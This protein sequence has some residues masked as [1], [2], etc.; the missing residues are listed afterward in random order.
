MLRLHNSALTHSHISSSARHTSS[1]HPT[2][3]RSQSI[4][5]ILVDRFARPHSRIV[6]THIHTFHSVVSAS[7]FSRLAPSISLH[8]YRAHRTA[9][10]CLDAPRCPPARRW[11]PSA[12]HPI[13]PCASSDSVSL[14]PTRP[15]QSIPPSSSPSSPPTVSI[16]SHAKQSYRF[17]LL[18]QLRNVRVHRLSAIARSIR[19][20]RTSNRSALIRYT[21]EHP[22][23]TSLHTLLTREC[24]SR[25]ECSSQSVGSRDSRSATS[26]DS[27]DRPRRTTNSTPVP[28]DRAT[29]P[30]SPSRHRCLSSHSHRRT[31]TRNKLQ[32]TTD[33][34]RTHRR[35]RADPPQTCRRFPCARTTRNPARRSPI[36]LQLLK[37]YSVCA[38]PSR[39]QL[40]LHAKHNSSTVVSHGCCC[41]YHCC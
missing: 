13:P 3:V 32:Q 10:P 21:T 17:H 27:S 26:A 19:Q 25:T 7:H 11:P 14:P 4:R 15:T 1:T 33:T 30:S 22:F 34:A 2:E 12:T 23:I 24:I 39:H 20:R 18:V 41:G 38:V 35:C 29:P 9:R 16:I 8:S 36:P 28:S 6:Y 31:L 40:V 37:L 5:P